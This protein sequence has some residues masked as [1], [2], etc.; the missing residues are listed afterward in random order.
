MIRIAGSVLLLCASAAL[1]FGAVTGLKD[2]VK[3]L[4]LLIFALEEMERELQCRLT[5]MPELL[6]ALA[7]RLE[8]PVGGFFQLCVSGLKGLGGHTFSKIWF[9]AM[10]ASDLRLEEEDK[11]LLE[12]LGNSLGR[13]DGQRQCEAIRQVRERL[14]CNLAD[15][16]QRRDRL[17]RVYGTLGLAAGAFLVI[18]LL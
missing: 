10:E 4:T 14:V 16:T 12:E 9:G 18:V 2:R 13:Y 5:P 3:Q 1:G 17:G 6:N 7:Q 8:G 11:L 15:A